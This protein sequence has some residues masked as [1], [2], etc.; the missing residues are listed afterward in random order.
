MPIFLTPQHVAQLL[1]L[2][3]RTLERQRQTG[4][5]LSF[6]KVGRRVLYS[7]DIILAWLERQAIEGLDAG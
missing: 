6:C 3:V 2:S 7:R 5:G 1:D 4:R